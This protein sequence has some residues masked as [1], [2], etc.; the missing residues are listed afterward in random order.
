[1]VT[2]PKIGFG[3]RIEEK[4]ADWAIALEN[5]LQIIGSTIDDESRQFTLV[6]LSLP[7]PHG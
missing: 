3:S 7:Q 4:R 1:M 2:V 6:H 5:R